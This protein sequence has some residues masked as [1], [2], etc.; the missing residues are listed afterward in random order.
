[1]RDKF[2][3]KVIFFLIINICHVIM[4][5]AMLYMFHQ[6]KVGFMLTGAL[7]HETIFFF[8]LEITIWNKMRIIYSRIDF[9]F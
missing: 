7:T 2:F 9:F 6:Y 4:S 1:M 3:F 5:R 8:L